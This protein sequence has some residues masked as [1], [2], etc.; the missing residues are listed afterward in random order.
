MIILKL[1]YNQY[2]YLKYMKVNKHKNNL[3]ELIIEKIKNKTKLRI[4]N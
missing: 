2:Y 1:F 4:L 3:I